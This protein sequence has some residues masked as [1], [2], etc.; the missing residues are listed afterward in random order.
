MLSAG[1]LAAAA[2]FHFERDRTRYISSHVKLRQILSGYLEMPPEKLRFDIGAKGKPFIE[3]LA[4]PLPFNLSHSGDLALVAV[5]NGAEVGVDIEKIRPGPEFPALA[6]QF[7]S[8]G[9]IQWIS[10]L[11]PED[12]SPAFF[13]LWV[14]K[15]ACIKAAGGGL[16]IPLDQFEM[17]VTDSQATMHTE[18]TELTGPWFVHELNIAPGYCA[19]VAVRVEECDVVSI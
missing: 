10:S 2:R 18:A 7:F 9:E 14:L 16:S 6:R 4:R 13:R 5:S 19:A 8:V 1:E 12:R 11:A 15:E 3:G 17:R